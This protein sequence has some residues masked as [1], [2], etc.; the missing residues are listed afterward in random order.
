MRTRRRAFTLI[1]LLVVIAIIA[2]LIGL[3][4]PAVQKVRESAARLQCQNNLKQLGLACHNYESTFKAMPPTGASWAT[5]DDPAICV[6]V[7]PYIEQ[8]NLYNLFNFNKAINNTIE[9]SAARTQQVP[10]LLCPSD[11]SSG[12]QVDVGPRGTLPCGQTNYYASIGATADQRSTNGSLVGVFNFTTGPGGRGIAVK[13]KLPINGI[14]DGT[15]NTAMWSETTRSV[16]SSGGTFNWYDPTIIYLLPASDAGYSV[17]TPMTGPLFNE[18]NPNAM[19]QGQT[20]RCNSWDYGP[21]NAISYRGNEYYR[22][23][24][25]LSNYTHTIPPNYKGYDCGD[26]STYNTAHIAARSY[27][28]GGVNV[29]FAD[30]SVHF[31]ADSINFI[32]WRAMGTRSG[33]DLVDGSQIN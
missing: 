10:V 14:R 26:D 24:P 31:V 6:I 2:I 5:G 11:G 28:T 15:S 8:A 12:F 29:C 25:A 9:N 17:L 13:S 22:G 16:H 19:I 3:L 23:L 4:V 7:L 1:E 33:G 18:T 32:T 30:G 20:Y 21:T 27:H